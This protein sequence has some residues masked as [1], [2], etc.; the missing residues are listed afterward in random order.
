MP[1]E[2]SSYILKVQRDELE[3]LLFGRRV[4]YVNVSRGWSHGT[5]VLFVK[6]D[7]F[8]GSGIIDRFVG[9]DEMDEGGQEKKLSIENNWYGKIVFSKLTRFVPPVPV[10][11]TPAASPNP[12][13][14]H[15]ASLT[16][17]VA[18]R[19]EQMAPGKIIV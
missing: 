11:D 4:L 16:N 10:R 14:L 9:L 3:R 17:D 15:G 19:I 13:A 7:V 18:A 6:K 8:L 5:L 1:E 2:P 12:L